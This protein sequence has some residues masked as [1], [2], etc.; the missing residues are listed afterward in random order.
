MIDMKKTYRTRDGRE[1]RIYAVDHAG[2]WSV[3]GAVKSPEGWISCAWRLNGSSEPRL[4]HPLDLIEVKPRIKRTVWVN[5]YDDE[6]KTSY[7]FNSRLSALQ[8]A[9][10]N[11]HLACVKIEIDCEEGEGL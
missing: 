4:E 7:L 11:G 6:N 3:S 1:V 2:I 10:G 9:R 8:G 5:V